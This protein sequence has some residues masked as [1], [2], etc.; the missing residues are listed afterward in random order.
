[1]TLLIVLVALAAALW[2][3]HPVPARRPGASRAAHRR[4]AELPS[5]PPTRGSGR[6]GESATVY[7]VAD[8]LDLLALALR[9]GRGTVEAV[10]GVAALVPSDL[11]RPLRSVAAALRWGAQAE[12]AWAYA[13][14]AW[15]PAARAWRLAEAGGIAPAELVARAAS[16]LRAAEDRRIEEATARAGAMLVL[17]LGVTFLPG[18]VATTVVPVLVALAGDLLSEVAR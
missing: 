18:F 4:H 3:V 1:M 2:P 7:D 11:G 17:P 14:P 8:A 15:K 6:R 16:E 5:G 9:S 12:R 10:E 13:P